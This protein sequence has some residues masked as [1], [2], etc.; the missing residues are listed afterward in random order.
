MSPESRPSSKLLLLALFLFLAAAAYWP[1]L[2]GG[3]V[4]D[5]WGSISGNANIQISESS[6]AAW[7]RA[8]ISFPSGTPP[9]RSLTMASFA[10]NHLFGGL[11][12]FGFKLTNLVI[13]LVNGVL[14][15]LALN[16]L[17]ALQGA[18]AAEKRL[19]PALASPGLAAAAIAGLWLLLPINLTAVLY[20]VQRLE[21]LA[22]TFIFLGLWWYLRARLKLWR[23]GGNGLG[24]W[25][26]IITCTVLGSFC[27]EVGAMLPL[28]AALIEFCITSGRNRNGARSRS[29]MYLYGTFLIA[30]MLIGS[31]WLWL[32]F[33]GTDLQGNGTA[34]WIRLLTEARVLCD[35]IGW[36]LVPNLDSLTLYHDDIARSTNLLS[37]PTTILS[38]L[39][40][41]ALLSAALWQ[42]QRR[43]LFALGILWFF[44]GHLLT[45]TIIPL[46]LA[47][48][49]RN[50]FSS[51]GLLL[52]ALSLIFPIAGHSRV[53]IHHVVVTALAL[54]YGITLWMR[55]AE[56]SEPMRLAHS[57]ATKRP[58][59]AA[60]QFDYAQALLIEGQS[61]GKQEPVRAAMTILNGAR[62]LPGASIHFEQ[63]MI[64]VLAPSGYTIPPDLWRSLIAKLRDEPPDTN[65][66]HAL[67]RLNH[68][69]SD[70]VCSAA[71]LP[72]LALAY[73][74]A[75][76]HPVS[77]VGILSI[78][79]EYA[80][81]VLNAPEVT[82][83]DYREV[84][85]I[86]PD[87]LDAKVN[88]IV[89]LIYRKKFDEAESMIQA[90]ES[91][92]I[93]G[94]LDSYIG[95]LRLTLKNQ[96]ARS[97]PGVGAGPSVPD[98]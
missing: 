90:M 24:L 30:P 21:S 98:S 75:L 20:V 14:L 93:L 62:K 86:H 15:F 77:N 78:H 88:L 94:T 97:S 44:A 67:S 5:D 72:Q 89:V 19:A 45:G 10:A 11:D 50:Y 18:V 49:H 46:A 63:T 31:A 84:V 69:F 28:Y 60:A 37:P 1:G 29:V 95:P 52:G 35:Y 91:R 7:S 25:L 57:E 85:R 34:A 17:F 66:I 65:A 40:L 48:E 58:A 8:A 70:K 13:H 22:T 81:H 80:W 42:Q 6:W 9:F 92:N 43:P 79:G 23:D 3:F 53:K 51:A 64:G 16:A 73:D 41:A 82:E 55:A 59:S 33:V 96:K 54:F 74:A 26:S 2:H 56:W 4:Y 32:K 76:S 12:P 36:T 83:R 61:T 47:F 39:A 68:C 38:I 27:K 71:D 87:D